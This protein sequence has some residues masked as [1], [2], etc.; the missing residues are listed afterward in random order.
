LALLMQSIHWKLVLVVSALHAILFLSITQL[1]LQ[2]PDHGTQSVIS[3][4][5]VESKPI[6]SASNKVTFSIAKRAIPK[7]EGTIHSPL[8]GD[9][10]LSIVKDGS[11]SEFMSSPITPPSA[12]A[13]AL[14]NPKPPYPISSRENGEQGA[15]ML[16]ACINQ[17]GTVERVDLAQSSGHPA[18][19]RSALNTVRHWHFAP[20]QEGGKSISMCYRL[21]IRFLLSLSALSMPLA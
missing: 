7:A 9:D 4:R 16:H 1:A 20:A 6:A 12:D 17:R 10:G 3:A 19:D 18:L 11:A 13:Y 15:V 14:R 8:T 5:L 21:P 2:A